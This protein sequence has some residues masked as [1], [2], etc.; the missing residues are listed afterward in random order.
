VEKPFAHYR[1]ERLSFW[2]KQREKQNNMNRGA[3]KLI[4]H[5]KQ[6]IIVTDQSKFG[7]M[8]FFK[9]A[10]LQEIDLIISDVAAPKE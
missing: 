5:S 8:Q 1:V 6:S 4:G 10:D 3:R 7:Q 9:I 2:M